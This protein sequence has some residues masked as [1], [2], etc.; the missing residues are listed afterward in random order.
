M[1]VLSETQLREALTSLDGWT[2]TD[3]A[4]QRDVTGDDF[5]TSIA[6]VNRVADAA[7]AA[8]HHPDLAISWDTV[9][10]RL[11]T[12]SDG[13]ITDKDVAMAHT[14]DGLAA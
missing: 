5:A 6:F 8:D 12:H 2:V 11:V 10:V 1:P 9:T 7:E 4:L 13:G 14:V 3:G